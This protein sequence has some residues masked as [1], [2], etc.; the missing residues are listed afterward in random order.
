MLAGGLYTLH[1]GPR[2]HQSRSKMVT[3]KE[4]EHSPQL[5][6][7]VQTESEGQGKLQANWVPAERWLQCLQIY[8]KV[9]SKHA[10]VPKEGQEEEGEKSKPTRT[11]TRGFQEDQSGGPKA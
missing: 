6:F 7:R 8:P 10:E 5:P 3:S 9:M 1:T 2:P 4:K 11:R